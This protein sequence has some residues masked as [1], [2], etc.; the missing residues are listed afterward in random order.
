MWCKLNAILYSAFKSLLIVSFRINSG[1]EKD[2]ATS[3]FE[4]VARIDRISLIGQY[5]ARGNILVLPI[6]GNGPANLTFGE[7]FYRFS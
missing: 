5:K 4:I 2:P 6:H 3:N 1:F 7:L